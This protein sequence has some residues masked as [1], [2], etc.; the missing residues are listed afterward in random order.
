M[1][2]DHKNKYFWCCH[3]FCCLPLL[4][5]LTS[6]FSLNYIVVIIIIIIIVI[7]IIIIIVVVVVVV[8]III[9]IIILS[10][11]INPGCNTGSQV[12]IFSLFCRAEHLRPGTK[13][14]NFQPELN[15]FTRIET[16]FLYWQFL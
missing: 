11:C 8:I 12:A 5:S 1:S 16:S 2:R 3:C 6:V 14:G 10:S 15:F 4:S 13:K 7:I 9:V